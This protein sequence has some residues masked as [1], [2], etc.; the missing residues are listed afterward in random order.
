MTGSTSY[1][2]KIRRGCDA[3]RQPSAASNPA[4]RRRVIAATA[5]LFSLALQ[6]FDLRAELLFRS[7]EQLEGRQ[8]WSALRNYA[9]PADTVYP[10]TLADGTQVA[11]E[12]V[13]VFL[14]G[15]I[16][17]NDVYGAKVMES[18]IKRGRQRIA[19]NAVS[20]TGSGGDVDAAMELGRLL[21]RLGVA[22]FV[23]GGGQCLS[24]CV[25]A[26][27]GGDRRTV[28]GR[29]GIHRPYFSST[30]KVPDRR[31]YYRQLQKRLRLYIEELDFPPSLYEAMMAVPPESIRILTAADLKKFYLQG[32]SPSTEDEMD[33][34]AA[35]NLGISVLEYLQQK[36][37]AQAC[38][39]VI[40]ADGACYG[41]AQNAAGSTGAAAD[42]RRTQPYDSASP[43]AD[44]VAQQK[45][46]DSE[47]PGATRGAAK[48]GSE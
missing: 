5:L 8:R 23:A 9:N 1:Q 43:A 30:R 41:E 38:A 42:L 15:D 45:K 28:A 35:R 3:C 34:A 24:S 47:G 44:G 12:E 17:P 20:L 4:G 27:M 26:F 31:V 6:C 18:L 33:A 32:M 39:G 19:G 48:I 11:S 22:T 25:F 46:A 16:R 10:R 37:Q 13:Q 2:G 21:R 14:Q 40:G 36:A 29:I 7:A